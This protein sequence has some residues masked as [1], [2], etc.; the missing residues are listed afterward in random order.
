MHEPRSNVKALRQ[1][2]GCLGLLVSAVLSGAGDM[3]AAAPLTARFVNPEAIVSVVIRPRQILG[4]L[5]DGGEALSLYAV[6]AA[7]WSL[8][9]GSSPQHLLRIIETCGFLLHDVEEIGLIGLGS[10]DVAHVIRFVR[11]VDPETGHSW[12]AT[13]DRVRSSVHSPRLWGSA[14]RR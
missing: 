8:L 10:G 3:V 14:T 4:R 5:A 1:A 12:S 2:V 7:R 9:Q 6:E 13:P 11:P